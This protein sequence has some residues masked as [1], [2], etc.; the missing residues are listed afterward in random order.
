MSIALYHPL[1]QFTSKADK[2][3]HHSENV[4]R[5]HQLLR[6]L[7]QVVRYIVFFLSLK[8]SVQPNNIFRFVRDNSVCMQQLNC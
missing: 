7:C 8:H 5:V 3:F 4:E 2:C 1:I 6:I